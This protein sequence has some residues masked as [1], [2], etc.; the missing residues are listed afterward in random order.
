VTACTDCIAGTY[1]GAQG[2]DEAADCIGC[3]AGSIT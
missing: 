1:V 3:A 2:S